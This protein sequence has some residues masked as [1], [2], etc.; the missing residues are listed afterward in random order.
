[1]LR[2]M[3]AFPEQI[4]AIVSYSKHVFEPYIE[5]LDNNRSPTTAKAEENVHTSYFLNRQTR[6]AKW[7]NMFHMMFGIKFIIGNLGCVQVAPI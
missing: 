2:S 5:K 3:C 6:V 4:A 7:S 1:M